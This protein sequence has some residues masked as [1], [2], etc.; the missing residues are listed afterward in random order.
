MCSWGFPSKG[1]NPWVWQWNE[2]NVTVEVKTADF[3]TILQT[4]NALDL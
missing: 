2:K 4:C 1:M 3:G